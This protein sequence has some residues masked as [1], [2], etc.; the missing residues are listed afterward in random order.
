[1]IANRRFDVKLIIGPLSLTARPALYCPD[2]VN[3]VKLGLQ[4]R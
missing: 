3:D 2:G 4:T 1:M